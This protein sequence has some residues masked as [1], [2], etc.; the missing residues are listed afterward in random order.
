M[1][2]RVEVVSF[3]REVAFTLDLSGVVASIYQSLSVDFQ[4]FL[5]KLQA[6]ETQVK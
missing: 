6:E 4:H 3:R 5:P 2:Q 1:R